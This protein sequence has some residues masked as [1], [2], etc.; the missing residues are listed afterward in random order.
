MLRPDW[1]CDLAHSRLSQKTLQQI[2]WKENKWHQLPQRET[3]EVQKNARMLSQDSQIQKTRKLHR[4]ELDKETKAMD[5]P[6]EPPHFE[7]EDQD[8]KK[9][10]LSREWVQ[11]NLRYRA[12][13]TFRKLSESDRG[14]WVEIQAGSILTNQS[15]LTHKAGAPTINY[16]QGSF[17]ACVFCSLASALHSLGDE[18]GA[19]IIAQ[20]A[21]HP[22][23]DFGG[24]SR[25]QVAHEALCGQPLKYQPSG[26]TLQRR[27]NHPLKV[28]HSSDTI[29]LIVTD[30]NHCFVV[31][32]HWIFDLNAE[33]ALEWSED[34]LAWC[35]NMEK[36][37]FL[38]LE[39][40]R[41]TVVTAHITRCPIPS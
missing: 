21:S 9:C 11:L 5:D 6:A 13:S 30:N 2:N 33:K 26:K 28:V 18:R 31:W 25:I 23:D 40:W 1:V 29:N 14:M 8:G 34:S 12:V 4:D 22:D 16:R 38:P 37:C 10:F 27:K 35:C 41:S 32:Q 15:L 36:M 39:V 20:L 24:K 7:G 17:D 19:G 3:K